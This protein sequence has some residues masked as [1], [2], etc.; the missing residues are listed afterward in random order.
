MKSRI[1]KKTGEALPMLGFGVMRL[2][3]NEDKTIDREPAAALLD[4]AYEAGIRYFDTA[5]GYLDGHSASFLGE[6]L[7]KYPRES[8]KFATKMPMWSVNEKEDVEKIFSKQLSD[9]RTDYVDFYLLHSLD[10]N[11]WQK[12]KEFGA[13]EFLKR[14]KAEGIIKNYGFSFHGTLETL[15]EVL[16]ADE[17]D[18]V[19]IQLNYLDWYSGNA[20]AEYEAITSRGIQVIVMEP[21]RGGALS[22]AKLSESAAVCLPMTATSGDRV[23][24]FAMRFAGSRSEVLTV[25]SGMNSLEQ[26][27]ENVR[28]FSTEPVFTRED[29]AIAMKTVNA[30]KEG[31]FIPCTDCRYCTEECPMDINIPRLF[32]AYNSGKEITDE[33]KASIASCLKCGLCH[34]RCPQSLDIP[35]LLPTLSS[36]AK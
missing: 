32:A 2:P 31:R 19:Q 24:E 6:T 10:A 23:A 35:A 18:F 34:T 28:T 21:V 33:M 15:N 14:K 22:L 16:D 17:W 13:H 7:E 4:A 29:E 11:F 27:S 12:A 8:I 20:K 30:I 3:Q 5:Y 25:L 9:L 36:P 1:F 26:I